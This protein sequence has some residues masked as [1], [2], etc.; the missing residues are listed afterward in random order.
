MKQLEEVTYKLISTYNF[1]NYSPCPYS[2]DVNVKPLEVNTY[3]I[4]IKSIPLRPGWRPTRI[5]F[6]SKNKRQTFNITDSILTGDIFI[7]YFSN[8]VE[9]IDCERYTLILE[10]IPHIAEGLLSYLKM[11]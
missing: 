1:G 6:K 3:S 9:N 7:L 4:I 10:R 5:V 8:K 2:L 11:E